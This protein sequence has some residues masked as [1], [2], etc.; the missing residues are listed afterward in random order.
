M[1]TLVLNGPNANVLKID[2]LWNSF[3]NWWT[4]HSYWTE[5]NKRW[6]YFNWI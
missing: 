4:L 1:K 5:Q 3:H 6:I 2:S